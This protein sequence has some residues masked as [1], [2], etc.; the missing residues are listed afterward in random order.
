M[1]INPRITNLAARKYELLAQ[2]MKYSLQILEYT[3][4]TNMYIT[5]VLFQVSAHTGSSSN[6]VAVLGGVEF[7]GLGLH[8]G[9]EFVRQIVD[10]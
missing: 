5:K 2:L 6:L 9:P 10:I 7:P 4:C 3:H 8:Y 1:D